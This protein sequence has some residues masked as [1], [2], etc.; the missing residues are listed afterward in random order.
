MHDTS[1][2]TTGGQSRWGRARVGALILW[3]VLTIFDCA[4]VLHRELNAYLDWEEKRHWLLLCLSE[5][6]FCGGETHYW[7]WHKQLFLSWVKGRKLLNKE[8]ITGKEGHRVV[9]KSEFSLIG[10]SLTR[11]QKPQNTSVLHVFFYGHIIPRV[12]NERS[13]YI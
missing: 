12:W 7:Q 6:M 11:L 9:R 1:T 4:I 8:E 3:S 10:P 5:V 13:L 2:V